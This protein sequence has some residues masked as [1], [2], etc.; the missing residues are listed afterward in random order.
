MLLL[1]ISPPHLCRSAVG[2]L[3]K[4]M[5]VYTPLGLLFNQLPITLEHPRK[6]VAVLLGAVWVELSSAK[7]E[8]REERRASV[9]EH[10]CYASACGCMEIDLNTPCSLLVV[11]LYNNRFVCTHTHT[12]S[13]FEKCIHIYIYMHIHF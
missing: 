12:Q 6:D 7:H 11:G 5:H 13:H 10:S 2:C 3:Q 1:N 8:K 4:I 9:K